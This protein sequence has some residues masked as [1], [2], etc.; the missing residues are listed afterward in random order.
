MTR[1]DKRIPSAE[2]FTSPPWSIWQ[3]S[4]NQG[5]T[6]AQLE[7]N[8][9][10]V[11][12]SPLPTTPLLPTHTSSHKTRQDKKEKTKQKKTRKDRTEQNR[13]EQNK[14]RQKRQDKK[15][16]AK[17]NKTRQ[18]LNFASADPSGEQNQKK[19]CEQCALHWRFCPS[20]Q[21]SHFGVSVRVRV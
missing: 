13:I 16:K 19:S 2:I 7:S 4:K 6:N 18:D 3:H 9:Q 12:V 17:Q 15:D 21:H 5:Q 11:E 1:Q 8:R 20:S 10:I 14:T